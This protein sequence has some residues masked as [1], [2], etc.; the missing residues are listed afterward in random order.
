MPQHIFK[1]TPAAS[2]PT[3][4][5]DKSALFLDTD[6]LFKARNEDGVL[7]G[8]GGYG[9]A[10]ISPAQLV[11]NTNDWAPAGYATAGRIRFSTD[12]SRDLTGIVALGDGVRITL[13]NIGA[14]NLVL[15]HDATSTAANRFYGPNSADHTIRPNGAAV[16]EYDLASTRWR[17]LAA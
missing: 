7:M 1:Q 11:A 14:F 16:I 15:K 13:L 2:I 5:T 4:D 6:A 17:V 9:G 12:A 3:P 8:L 10:A